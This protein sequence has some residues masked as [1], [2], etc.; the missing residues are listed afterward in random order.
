VRLQIVE[1][2]RITMDDHLTLT[3]VRID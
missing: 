3:Q 2:G 1:S